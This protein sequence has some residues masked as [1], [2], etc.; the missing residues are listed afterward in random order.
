MYRRLLALTLATGLL[1]ACG[2]ESNKQNTTTELACSDPTVVQ[3]IRNNIQDIIKQ[4]ARAFARND[5]R[6]FVD[7][8]KI[9][10]AG[11]LL[12]ITLE[13]AQTVREGNKTLCS[14]GLRIIIPTD[15]ANSAATNSPL[16]YGSSSVGEIIKQKI[17]GSNLSYSGNSFTTTIRYTPS[18]TDGV[19]L[20]D[21]V[22][23]ST[24]Q[25]L[26]AALLPYGVKS[27]VMIDGQAVTKEEAIR[28]STTQAFNEPPEADP[29]DILENNAASQSDGIPQDL[30]GLDSHTEIISPNSDLSSQNSSF[31]MS[32]LESARAQNRQAEAEINGVWNNMERSV[33]QG[34]LDEQRSWIQSKSQNCLQAATPADNPAQAEYLQLQCDTRMTRERTQYLRGFTIH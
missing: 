2:D 28:L 27:I 1:A 23:T 13:D 14:A 16:I 6:Q 4:E 11:S 25:T 34:I 24:A 18:K 21:N 15:I 17:M 31:S 10:A 19:S 7:A 12:D 33:Q 3:N 30:I 32:D 8:D 9:I 26:S 20:E 29:E 5:S 22:V